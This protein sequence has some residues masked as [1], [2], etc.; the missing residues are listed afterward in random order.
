MNAR[1]LRIKIPDLTKL[2]QLELQRQ[3]G[4]DE[5]QIEEPEEGGQTHGE[6]AT[7]TAIVIVSLAALRVIAVWLSKSHRSATYKRT[8]EVISPNDTKRV[9]IQY[10]GKSDEP[11][12]ADVLNQLAKACELD[13]GALAN[14]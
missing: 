4:A 14:L 10:D 11:P 9:T 2:D 8:V 13:V 3:L 6:L 1:D 5:F 7:A 12:D